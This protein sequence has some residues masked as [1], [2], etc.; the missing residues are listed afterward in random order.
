MRL[1]ELPANIKASN[2]QLPKTLVAPFC[3]SVP[4]IDKALNNQP[5]TNPSYVEKTDL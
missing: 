5:A 1:C 3:N 2:Q 4:V